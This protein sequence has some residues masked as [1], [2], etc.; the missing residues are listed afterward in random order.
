ME[1]AVGGHEI[2]EIKTGLT[3]NSE[4]INMLHHSPIKMKFFHE[5]D[6]QLCEFFFL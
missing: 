4:I 1:Q 5:N 2:E 6:A 3:I